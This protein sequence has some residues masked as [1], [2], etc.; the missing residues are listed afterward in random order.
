MEGG[1]EGSGHRNKP[2]NVQGGEGVKKSQNSA[3][4]INGRHSTIAKCARN[5]DSM[6][7]V[8]VA[9]CDTLTKVN[10]A[11]IDQFP[12]NAQKG[13]EKSKSLVQEG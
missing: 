9:D 3:D 10:I 13:M 6:N 4:V 7:Y 12:L 5:P 8:I 2:I 11:V 1:E